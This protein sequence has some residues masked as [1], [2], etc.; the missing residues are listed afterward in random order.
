MAVQSDVGI[1]NLAQDLLG[2][3]ALASITAP[4]STNER[5]YARHY[6]QVRDAE[7]RK[8]RWHFAKQFFEL[9]PTGDPITTDDDVLYQYQLPGGW[10]RAIRERYSDWTPA[11]GR[12][13]SPTNGVIKVWLVMRVT[14]A[15][16]DPL[17]VDVLAG[18]LAARLAESVTQSNEKKADAKE[19]YKAALDAARVANAFELGPEG[20]GDDD[21]QYSWLAARYA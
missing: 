2:A 18:S 8:H 13:L 15:L 19:Y 4:K 17:F 5:L 9:T 6:P 12:L 20:I 16:F 1:C 11:G 14:E 3:A 10:I 21:S 7:L